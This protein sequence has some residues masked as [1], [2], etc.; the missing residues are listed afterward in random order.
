MSQYF[1]R[2]RAGLLN[3]CGGSEYIV[4]CQ[5]SALVRYAVLVALS[6]GVRMT[7]AHLPKMRRAPVSGMEADARC[8]IVRLGVT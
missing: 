7:L 3:F 5:A 8:R 2:I 4:S 1:Q 6:R